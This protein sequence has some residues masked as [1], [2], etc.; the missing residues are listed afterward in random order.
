MMRP[1]RRQRLA[2]NDSEDEAAASV[3]NWWYGWG[4]SGSLH[5]RRTLE[6]DDAVAAPQRYHRQRTLTGTAASAAPSLEYG[7]RRRL[8]LTIN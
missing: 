3:L 4:G 7:R 6:E 8:G 1:G 5:P 2:S